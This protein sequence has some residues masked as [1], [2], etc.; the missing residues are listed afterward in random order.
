MPANGEQEVTFLSPSKL[1]SGPAPGLGQARRRGRLH[2]LR[3]R[4]LLHVHHPAVDEGPGRGRPG[5]LDAVFV[6]TAL[7]PDESVA[8]GASSSP[9]KVERETRRQFQART[10]LSS[11]DYAAVFLLNIDGLSAD[12]W[13]KLSNYVREGGGLVVAPGD[14]AEP[15]GYG[16]APRR[17]PARARSTS[18]EARPAQHDFAKAEYDHPIFN[19]HPGCS[20]PT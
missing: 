2:G 5:G 19:R 1:E 14:R 18:Q 3:R 4:P 13:G 8:P 15:S 12:D 11:K 17:N 6:E 16:S 20:T 10:R 9:Y 7:S